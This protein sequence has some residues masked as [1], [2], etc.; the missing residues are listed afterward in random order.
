ML[1]MIC[2]CVLTL[3]FGRFRVKINKFK[4]S[5]IVC[6]FDWETFF[7][8]PD[9]HLAYSIHVKNRFYVLQSDHDTHTEESDEFIQA[10]DEPK[11]R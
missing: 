6:L 3:T 10:N 1:T 4:F 2:S 7:E 5:I 9:L 8:R 11:E